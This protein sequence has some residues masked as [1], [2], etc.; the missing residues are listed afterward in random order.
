MSVEVKD[1]NVEAL[2][3]GLTGLLTPCIVQ[4]EQNVGET[5]KS[6]Q[7]LGEQIDKLSMEL[8]RITESTKAPPHIDIYIR[9]LLNAKRKIIVINSVLQ[10]TQERANKLQDNIRRNTAKY[11]AQLDTSALKTSRR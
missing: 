10:S 11:Q 5:Q 2:T 9:K 1:E 7:L 4:L 8:R 6:Q 3:E